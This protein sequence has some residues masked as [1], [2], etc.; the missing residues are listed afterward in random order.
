MEVTNQ[1]FLAQ[2]EAVSAYKLKIFK[3]RKNENQKINLNN[4][5]SCI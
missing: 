4:N 5:A 2:A 3:G 1:F